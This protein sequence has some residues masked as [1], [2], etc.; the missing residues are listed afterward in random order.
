M[1]GTA[2]QSIL[3]GDMP[4]LAVAKNQAV[5]DVTAHQTAQGTTVILA[6][7]AVSIEKMDRAHEALTTITAQMHSSSP[8]IVNRKSGRQLSLNLSRF[9]PLT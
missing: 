3:A 2:F 9:L 5:H 7:P 1:P 8:F 4:I 6:Y